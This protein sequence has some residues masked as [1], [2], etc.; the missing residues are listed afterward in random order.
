MRRLSQQIAT[1]AAVAIIPAS[2]S[3]FINWKREKW[4]AF[5]D[6]SVPLT[7]VSQWKKPVLWVDARSA[8]D[9]SAEHVPGAIRLT[10]DDWNELLPAV[11]SAWESDQAVIVYC[12]SRKCHA[13]EEVAKR[14]REEVGLKSVFVLRGG[15][16]AWKGAQR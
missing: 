9:F 15:W 16:E 13:S 8:G 11:L 5:Q 6:T 1:L 10:E 3:A 12:S 2:I 4:G 14:L 7:Q